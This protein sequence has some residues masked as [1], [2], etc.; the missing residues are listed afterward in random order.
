[1]LGR[2]GH[3]WA[4]EDLMGNLAE[5]VDAERRESIWT[6]ARAL[7]EI[8]SAE[9]IP[10]MIGLIKD[11]DSYDTVYGIGYFGLS[12]LTGVNYDEKHDGAWWRDWWVKN[13]DRYPAVRGV[14]IRR[15]GV[16]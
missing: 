3:D 13:R 11:G 8:G 5:A 6:A 1:A 10:A 4:L 12:G 7:A 15:T 16:E 9:A 14:E 2:K